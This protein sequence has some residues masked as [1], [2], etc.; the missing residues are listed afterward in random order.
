[1]S[2]IVT[3]NNLMLAVT[4]DFLQYEWALRPSWQEEM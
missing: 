4:S 1:M 2:V 3:G